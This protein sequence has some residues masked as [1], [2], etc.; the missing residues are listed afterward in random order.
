MYIYS[1]K[2]TLLY[3]ITAVTNEDI[4]DEPSATKE[5]EHF[6]GQVELIEDQVELIEDEVQ[7]TEEEEG[8]I[9]DEV[10]CEE[11]PLEDKVQ[12]QD[13]IQCEDEVCFD[14]E[15]AAALGDVVDE[16][17]SQCEDEIHSNG[18]NSDSDSVADEESI[19]ELEGEIPKQRTITEEE[20]DSESHYE[21]DDP[22]YA[23]AVIT[24]GVAMTLLLAFIVRHKLTNEAISDLLYLIDHMCPKPNRCCKTL[25][26][27]K[28]F[29]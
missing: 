2:A 25:Y 13:D 11:V 24:V 4:N 14:E 22:L 27:F 3:P 15:F 7:L 18:L 8:L 26:K 21:H 9:E 28:E 16:C 29:F 12:P 20:T 6:E 23:G 1:Y 5:L 17:S 10:E 19:Q